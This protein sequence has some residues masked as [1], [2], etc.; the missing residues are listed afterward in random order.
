[1]D[2]HDFTDYMFSP[3]FAALYELHKDDYL[4]FIAQRSVRMNTQ[5][6]LY[7]S[8]VLGEESDPE[9]LDTLEFIYSGKLTQQLSFQT[10][11]FFN[12]ND[13]IAWDWAQARS[14][15]V[16][17]L[18][19]AGLEVETEYRQEGLR[20][21]LNH[22]FVKQLDWDLDDGVLVSGI[23]YSDYYQDAGS[24]VIITSNGNDL[25]NWPNHA[26]KLFTRLDLL[27]GRLCLHGNLRTLWGF[28]GSED[29]LDALERAGGNAAE[30]ADIR[31]HDAYDVQITANVSLTWRIDKTLAVTAFVQN[32][33]VLGDNKRYAYSSGFKNSYPDKVSWVEEPTVLGVSCR[34]DF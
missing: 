16:G 5:E 13:V 2:K 32:I 31:Q 28:E 11:V 23:S 20:I 22:S 12:Q 21:G 4:K 7:M 29:G 14:A 17:T 10:S 25:N 33:P 3:R 1:V 27:D 18:Q 34:L 30:I 19:T 8:H 15:P 24:G 26:T 6:E 9:K